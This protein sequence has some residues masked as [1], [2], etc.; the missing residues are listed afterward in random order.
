[1][2]RAKV[3]ISS[4][5]DEYE[6]DF[7]AGVAIDSV[8]SAE[9]LRLTFREGEARERL[10]VRAAIVRFGEEQAHAAV[11]RRAD[12]VVGADDRV[13]ADRREEHVLPAGRYVDVA[14]ET[15]LRE[16][17]KSGVPQPIRTKDLLAA[18]GSATQ[19]TAW[20][21]AQFDHYEEIY[22]R[23]AETIAREHKAA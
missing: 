16:A 13:G 1:M 10:R 5:D 23:E 8:Q 18:L 21:E 6:G 11:G 9:A 3:S 17:M 15:K 14:V 7:I 12:Q 20:H 4:S 19:G 22:G 2:V